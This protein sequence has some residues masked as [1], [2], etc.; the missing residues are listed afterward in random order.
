M[1]KSTRIKRRPYA[2]VCKCLCDGDCSDTHYK[3]RCLYLQENVLNKQQICQENP[4]GSASQAHG[5]FLHVT[6]VLVHVP[7]EGKVSPQNTMANVH[8]NGVHSYRADSHV[9]YKFKGN[10]K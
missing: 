4:Q 5:Q 6:T 8:K 2:A 10:K 9:M 7:A 1:F 3:V